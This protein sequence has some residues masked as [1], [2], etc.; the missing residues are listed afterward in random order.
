MDQNRS[1]LLSGMLSLE[2]ID[3]NVFR[4]DGP[5]IGGVVGPNRLFGGHVVAQTYDAVKKFVKN[6]TTVF[7]LHYNFVSTGDPLKAI[8]FEL[9]RTDDIIRVIA[10]HDKKIIGLAH[11][12]LGNELL[13]PPKYVEDVP[14]LI[15]LL[16][17]T[18]QISKLPTD[19]LR[20]RY[21]LFQNKFIFDIRPHH[22]V[23]NPAPGDFRINYYARLHPTALEKAKADD[24]LTVVIAL[25]DFF[26]LQSSQNIINSSGYRLASG[27]SLH[28]KVMLHVS[29]VEVSQWFLVQSRTE[30]MSGNKAKITGHIYNSNKDGILTFIQEA[31][32]VAAPPLSKI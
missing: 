3:D 18:K 27:A 12:K 15:E 11:V 9:S 6:E 22:L 31:Y 23:T 24:G 21:S 25:S 8:H 13:E 32:V 2:K 17:V 14:Q 1:K 29:N 10:S 30:L 20:K 28:H 5:H 16:E 7:S 4:S 26:S 19:R